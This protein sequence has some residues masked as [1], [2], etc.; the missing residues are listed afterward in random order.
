MTAG[1]TV[2]DGDLC[3]VIAGT[4]KGRAGTVEDWKL[5][6]SGHATITVRAASGERFKTL[7]RNVRKL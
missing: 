5:S 1:G 3:E 2:R 4:H 6:K 7:A